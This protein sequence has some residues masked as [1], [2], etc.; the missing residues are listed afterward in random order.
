MSSRTGNQ[1]G[2]IKKKILLHRS[3]NPFL[4]VFSYLD[5]V[6]GL[7][8]FRTLAKTQLNLS[9]ELCKFQKEF[10]EI[11][12]ANF[13]ELKKI[14]TPFRIPISLDSQDMA[15]LSSYKDQLKKILVRKVNFEGKYEGK[16]KDFAIFQPY[17]SN[18]EEIDASLELKEENKALVD[19]IC[20]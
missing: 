8:K 2:K 13:E 16:L 5:T 6:D 19:F 14:Q 1:G 11:S 10:L 4:F 17:F 18:F 15:L 3:K 20:T 12:S 9:Q 7:T